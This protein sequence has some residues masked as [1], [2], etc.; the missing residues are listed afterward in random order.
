MT[1]PNKQNLTVPFF[2][3][4]GHQVIPSEGAVIK[5]R[6]GVFALVTTG[7]AVLMVWP[8]VT[9]GIPEL[10]G[11]G[12]KEGETVDQ[13]MEREWR[14]EVG[15]DMSV[16]HGPVK[17]YRHVRGFFADDLDEF[18][19]YDQTFQLFDFVM[20]VTTHDKW[21]NSEGDL[22]GWE[23]LARLQESRMNR[24]HWLAVKD[25]LPE[26]GLSANEDND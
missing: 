17:E 3:R 23:P 9:N 6:R 21:P 15:I 14:E 13:A 18:W 8:K 10:P 1:Q 2:T 11:G 20:S 12:I 25:L 22:A 7:T 26:L 4:H 5:P 19:I 24:A 16:M